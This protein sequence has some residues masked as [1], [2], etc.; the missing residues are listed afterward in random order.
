LRDISSENWED[1]NATMGIKDS[2]KINNQPTTKNLTN[3]QILLNS[4][5]S[6]TRSKVNNISDPRTIRFLI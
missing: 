4:M 1:R 2:L 5:A 6:S 3:L